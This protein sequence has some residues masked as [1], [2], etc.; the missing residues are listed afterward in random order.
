MQAAGSSS[1]STCYSQGPPFTNGEGLRQG[2]APP[3]WVVV[4]C[5]SSQSCLRCRNTAAPAEG[6]GC[7]CRGGSPRPSF[8]AVPEGSCL[9]LARVSRTRD[10]NRRCV[11]KC[12]PASSG[13]A[14]L[15]GFLPPGGVGPEYP[16]PPAG[17]PHPESHRPLPN[18]LPHRRPHSE[19]KAALSPARAARRLS[20]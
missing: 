3:S 10:R 8:K 2:P 15:H 19:G 5:A 7:G 12:R 17:S 1:S 20:L 18:V 16:H 13:P 4:A 11:C 9:E 14:A 6:L